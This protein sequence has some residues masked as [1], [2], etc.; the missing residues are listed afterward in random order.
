M[1]NIRIQIIA[2]VLIFAAACTKSDNQETTTTEPVIVSTDGIAPVLPAYFAMTNALVIEDS[3]GA[4][5]AGNAILAALEEVDMSTIA[6]DKMD[7]YLKLADLVKRSAEEIIEDAGHIDFQREHLEDLT[8]DMLDIIALIGSSQKLYKIHCP[9]AFDDKGADWLSDSR[10]V[11]N[12]YFG[13]LMLSC[14]FVA[15]EIE[16]AAI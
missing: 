11:V 15:E 12:P 10:E 14:G 8:M 2:F 7:Q 16:P 9:M 3:K 4:V 6:E 13:D 5:E 1:K